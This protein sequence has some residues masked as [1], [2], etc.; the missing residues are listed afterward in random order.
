MLNVKFY[1]AY[2]LI[3]WILIKK[4]QIGKLLSFITNEFSGCLLVSRVEFF[5]QKSLKNL[6]LVILNEPRRFWKNHFS[7]PKIFKN[8]MRL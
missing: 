4:I 6:I 5:L 7:E 8:K 1:F 2:Y 3:L